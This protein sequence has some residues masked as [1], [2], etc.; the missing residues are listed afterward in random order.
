MSQQV[1]K[2]MRLEV[3]CDGIMEN[4][5]YLLGIINQSDRE[6]PA[7]QFVA[8]KE[9]R[10]HSKNRIPMSK[11]PLKILRNESPIYYTI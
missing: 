11:L 4:L 6:H 10:Y 3:I 8:V 7:L 2:K 5:K 1:R 9:D